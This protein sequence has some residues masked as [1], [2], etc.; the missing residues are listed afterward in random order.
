MSCKTKENRDVE[1]TSV[2]I[3]KLGKTSWLIGEWEGTTDGIAVTEIWKKAS[4]NLL[5]GRSFSLKNSDTIS[6]E[7]IEL[8][9]QDDTVFYIPKVKNQNQGQIV[10]FALTSYTDQ[11]LI[12]E[13]PMHD[14]PQKITYQLVNNDS[15]VAE[16]SGINK[17]Q[18]QSEKFPTH[19]KH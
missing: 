6:S 1:K 5:L 16:I 2:V 12:F 7:H 4:G 13:N 8:K 11:T 17:G 9:L 19:R 3:S 18:M 15:L 14:F 10:K